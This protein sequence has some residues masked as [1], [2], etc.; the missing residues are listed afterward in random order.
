MISDS[1][2]TKW[3]SHLNWKAIIKEFK[4]QVLY[5]LKLKS[6]SLLERFQKCFDDCYNFS[7]VYGRCWCAYL[8]LKWFGSFWPCSTTVTW[9]ENRIWWFWVYS[10][11]KMVWITSIWCIEGVWSESLE[12]A[13]GDWEFVSYGSICA[14]MRFGSVFWVWLVLGLAW[15]F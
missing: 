4:V 13:R 3:P 14:Y 5:L 6:G 10:D 11:E 15:G 1:A 8:W 7:D 2:E 12:D 9:S